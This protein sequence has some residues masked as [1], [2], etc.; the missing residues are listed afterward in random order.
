MTKLKRLKKNVDASYADAANA[1][2]AVGAAYAAETAA[3]DAWFKVK[4]ELED[5]LREQDV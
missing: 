1:T 3:W 5:Y 4:L 2:K